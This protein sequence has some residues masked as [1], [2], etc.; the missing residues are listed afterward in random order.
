MVIVAPL[1]PLTVGESFVASKFPLHATLVPPFQVEC[2]W[3]ELNAVVAGLSHRTDRLLA[4]VI[5]QEGFGPDGSIKV[6]LIRA[7]DSIMNAH[8][9]LIKVLMPLGWAAQEGRYNG[10]GFRPHITGNDERHVLLGEHFI[11]SEIALIEMLDPPTV[12]ATHQ[13]SGEGGTKK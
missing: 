10:S 2:D 9:Q 5:G 12:R 4:D 3:P 1:E 7:T 6:A 8:L 13:M 11:L